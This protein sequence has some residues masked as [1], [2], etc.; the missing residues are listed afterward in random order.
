[1][2]GGGGVVSLAAVGWADKIV[3]H[4]TAPPPSPNPPPYLLF[5]VYFS[6]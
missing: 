1:M 5:P 6:L 4:S 3:P 2:G